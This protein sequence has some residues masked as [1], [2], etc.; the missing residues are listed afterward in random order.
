MILHD[1]VTIFRGKDGAVDSV[2]ATV[3]A[4]VSGPRN[5]ADWDRSDL[6]V[7]TKARVFLEPDVGTWF[8]PGEHF[9]QWRGQTL[10]PTGNVHT[11]VGRNGPVYTAV[12]IETPSYAL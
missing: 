12:E 5:V 11:G 3:P 7:S 1:S 4:Y 10:K 9:M 6:M 2:I 8:K